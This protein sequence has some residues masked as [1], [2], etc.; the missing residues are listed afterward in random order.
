MKR[1]LLVLFAMF[2]A[3]VADADP[4]VLERGQVWTFADAPADTARI[5]IGDVEPFGPV[6]PDGLTAV[7]VSIIGLPPTG[8]GQ[9]I[10]HLPFSEAALR[11]ALLE[12]ESSGAS[13]A[14]DYTGGYTTWKNAVDAGEA[15]IFTLTPAEVITHIFVTIGNAH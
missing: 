1:L 3:G 14:P 4:V 10:D 8:Y 7:S 5:I 13:L 15:G 11:P 9:V 6:G 2:G 12:L